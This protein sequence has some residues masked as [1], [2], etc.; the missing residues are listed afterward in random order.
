ME[1]KTHHKAEVYGTK[2]PSDKKI[3]TWG[4]FETSTTST[5]TIRTIPILYYVNIGVLLFPE[6][7]QQNID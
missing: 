4:L 7:Q 6:S 2:I 3:N 1:Y 5:A